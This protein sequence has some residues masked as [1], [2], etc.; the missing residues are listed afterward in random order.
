MS[1]IEN[2]S[3][4]KNIFDSQEVSAEK[5]DVIREVVD[6]GRVKMGGMGALSTKSQKR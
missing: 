2:Q 6:E 3:R 5:R 1:N 4:P